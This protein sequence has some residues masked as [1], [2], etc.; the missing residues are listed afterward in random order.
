MKANRKT[1]TARKIAWWVWI[2]PLLILAAAGAF[3]LSTQNTAAP[4]VDK[5][6]GEVSV[7]Q[8][9][10]MQSTGAFVLDVRTQEEWNDYHAPDSVL[11]PLDQLPSRLSELPRDQEI[12]VV[13][14]SGNRSA[15]AR[16]LLLD[17][18]F[19]KVTSMAGGLS[20]WKSQGFPTLTGP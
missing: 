2:I 10:E 3:L 16:D 7:K 5:L 17:A 9:V 4:A 20:Q 6:P 14:R 12:V 13:C 1:Q 18:G 11:I 8:A 19:G 15:T